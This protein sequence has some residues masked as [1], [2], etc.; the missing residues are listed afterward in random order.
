MRKLLFLL[1]CAASSVVIGQNK[2]WTLEECVRY[3]LEHNISIKQAELTRDIDE[4]N[5]QENKLSKYP[6]LNASMNRSHSFGRS[7]NPFDNVI[8]D[9]KRVSNSFTLNTGATLFNGFQLKN[10]EEQS[11]IRL[12]SRNKNLEKIR[13][14]ISLNIALFYLQVLFNQETITNN[15][16]QLEITKQQVDRIN[17]LVEVGS[18]A[19]GSLYE[20]ESQLASEEQKLIQS[21]SDFE[22]SRLNL[23]QLLDIEDYK[24][25]HIVKPNLRDPDLNAGGVSTKSIYNMASENLPQIHQ[26]DLDVM[27]AVKGVEIAESGLYPRLSISASLNTFNVEDA[28]NPLSNVEEKYLFSDQIENNFS[29]AV[30]LNLDIPIFNGKSARL[31]VERSKVQMMQAELTKA[32]T[33]NQLLK[34]IQKAQTDVLAAYKGFISAKKSVQS[35]QEAYNYV[36]KK[37]ELGIVNAVEHNDAKNKLNLA[38]SQMTQSKFDYIFKTMILEFYKGNPIRL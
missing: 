35:F 26:A 37:Y 29:Q 3:A 9:Q 12:E 13:N 23:T 6:T 32:N 1:C 2:T 31:G 36:K 18:L 28:L 10:R 24:S 17:K 11:E 16:A 25:F 7:V 4:I 19:K 34:D 8:T 33:E 21:E 38:I 27:D 14:D 20:I 22:I 15:R 5:L 30:Y